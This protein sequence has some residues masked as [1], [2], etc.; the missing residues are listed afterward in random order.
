[1]RLDPEQLASLDALNWFP[2]GVDAVWDEDALRVFTLIPEFAKED[3]GAQWAKYVH[4]LSLTHPELVPSENFCR[5]VA[6]VL[7]GQVPFDGATEEAAAGLTNSEIASL[8]QRGLLA[9]IDSL[10]LDNQMAYDIIKDF[11]HQAATKSVSLIGRMHAFFSLEEIN[12]LHLEFFV[13]ELRQGGRFDLETLMFLSS[14]P[15]SSR[16]V[17]RIVAKIVIPQMEALYSKGDTVGTLGNLNNGDEYIAFSYIS[18]H[19]KESKHLSWFTKRKLHDFVGAEHS[20]A[21]LNYYV[22]E[23]VINHLAMKYS[24]KFWWKHFHDPLPN[25]YRL[26]LPA[27]LSATVHGVGEEGVPP[28][29]ALYAATQFLVGIERGEMVYQEQMRFWA[30]PY[31]HAARRW[32]MKTMEADNVPVEWIVSL[33]GY[34]EQVAKEDFDVLPKSVK[35]HWDE[36]AEKAKVSAHV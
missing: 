17:L 31:M 9:R 21:W 16:D 34:D 2:D 11:S 24:P 7:D 5:R 29:I 13:S 3:K 25:R 8:F 15:L 23:D 18:H 35:I 6:M 30:I 36:M 4:M 26:S 22:G 19:L 1:M 27:D 32:F 12:P 14:H 33:L 20:S 28:G 10:G